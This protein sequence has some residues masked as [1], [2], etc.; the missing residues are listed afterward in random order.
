[1]P[2]TPA[3]FSAPT[4]RSV[5]AV[6]ATTTSYCSERTLHRVVGGGNWFP[7]SAHIVTL[8][9]RWLTRPFDVPPEIGPDVAVPPA[10]S[11]LASAGMAA[12]PRLCTLHL[13]DDP[14]TW[15]TAG[16][17]VRDEPGAAP[18]VHLGGVRLQLH[19]SDGPRGVLRWDFLTSETPASEDPAPPPEPAAGDID[20]LPTAWV[21]DPTESP[22]LTHPNRVGTI[23][24]IVVSS[25]DVDRTVAALTARGFRE[26]R[27]RTTGRY[28]EPMVQV[29]FWTGDVIL[30][31]VG[32]T[33]VPAGP[34]ASAAFFGLALTSTDPDLTTAQLGDL[35]GP[36]REAVQPG[37][38]ISTLRLDRIGG[39]VP[40]VVMSPHPGEPASAHAP[41]R[42]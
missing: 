39:S 14:S 27:R 13:G 21:S 37:R 7:K 17:D 15:R 6:P 2:E 19:G 29:F 22:A 35:L 20:G 31:L 24:H 42:Q 28:G 5:A 12:E 34:L 41:R 38:L 8:C 30:E 18:S 32:P 1:M 26:R 36:A 33:T 3:E 25:P 9:G 23:D 11:A 10:S 4:G 40:T 16:F